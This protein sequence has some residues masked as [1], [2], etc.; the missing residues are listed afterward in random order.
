MTEF[1]EPSEWQDLSALF[2]E[3]RQGDEI[4]GLSSLPESIQSMHGSIVSGRVIAVVGTSIEVSLRHS[5]L[6]SSFCMLCL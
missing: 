3:N 6:V 4:S 5:R 2:T 1:S